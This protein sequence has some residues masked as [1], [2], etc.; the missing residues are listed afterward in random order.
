MGR[1]CNSRRLQLYF[2]NSLNYN[3]LRPQ[4]TR[5]SFRLPEFPGALHDERRKTERPLGYP[6][7]VIH[8]FDFGGLT[9]V[10]SGANDAFNAA[11]TQGE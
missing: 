6:F 9:F 10:E 5:V 3:G 7:A 1:G 2:L 4:E 11:H 8:R